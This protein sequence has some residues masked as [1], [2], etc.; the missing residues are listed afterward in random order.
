MNKQIYSNFAQ[1]CVNEL[2]LFQDKFKKDFDIDS[3]ENWF[4]NQSTALL[5]FST[6][7]KELNFKY[8]EVG[9]FSTTTQTWKWS[10]D[11]EHTLYS[12]KQGIHSVKEFGE[13]VNYCKLTNGYFESNEVEAWEF[14][15]ITAKLVN[16][17]G[18][19]R[20]VSDNLLIF[21]VLLEY[22]DPLEANN[23][24]DRYVQCGEH[25]YKRRAFVCRHLNTE[26]KVGFEESFETYENM[27]L[28]DDD[29]LQAWCNECEHVRFREGE[30]NDISMKFAQ[31][32]V[33]CEDCY[34]EM[35]ELNLGHK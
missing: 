19:Y 14:T 28:Q 17:I 23:I 22:I 18:V 12:V 8:L 9:T 4:Y 3:Y 21:M 27:D 2:N 25:D 31:I 34:F 32:K 29:D 15:A 7:G 33:V 13:K 5:T 10:W 16:G 1:L 11:N 35:K 26:T 6:G 24:T 20:T 30:W